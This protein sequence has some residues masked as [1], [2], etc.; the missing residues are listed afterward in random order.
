[1]QLSE[2]NTNSRRERGRVRSAAEALNS[3][4]EL[5]DKRR[6]AAVSFCR[7]ADRFQSGYSFSV[8]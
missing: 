7:S 4:S 2:V 1:M 5:E 8:G 3:C 6:E